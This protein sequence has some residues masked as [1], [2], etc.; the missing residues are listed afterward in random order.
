MNTRIAF[1]F[2]RPTYTRELPTGGFEFGEIDINV[3][4]RTDRMKPAGRR[5]TYA[6]AEQER[7][8]LALRINGKAG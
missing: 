2:I 7:G 3:T 4:D 1:F 5:D 8:A 6:E